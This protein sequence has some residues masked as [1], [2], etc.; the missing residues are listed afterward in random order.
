MESLMDELAYK[1]NMD[2][3]EFRKKN[4]ADVAWHRQLDAVPRRLDGKTAIPNPARPGGH[5]CAA[6]DVPSAP[7]AAA[8]APVRR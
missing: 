4:V 5:W 7:G 1:I 8:D 2:P 6:W 3:V